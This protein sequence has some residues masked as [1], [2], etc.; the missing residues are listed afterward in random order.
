M[1]YQLDEMDCGPSCLVMIAKYYGKEF[2]LSFFRESSFITKNGVSLLGISQAAQTIGFET[3]SAKLTLDKLKEKEVELP[4]ILH[5]NQ[6]HFLVLYKIK[7]SRLLKKTYYYLADP[8][9][10]FIKID[11]E[12]FC[13][14]WIASSM[15]GIALYLTPGNSFF[16]Q[17]EI[18][19]QNNFSYLLNYIKPFKWQ[20]TKIFATLFLGSLLTLAFPFLTENLVDKGIKAK[21][22]NLVTLILLAQLFLFFGQTIVEII[23]NR[24]LLYVGSKININIIA[25]FFGKL[26]SMPL[27]YFDAKRIG[28][29]TQRIQDHKRI[30]NFLTSQS[31]QILFSLINFSV[32]FAVLAYYKWSLLLVYTC[33]TL[34]SILWVLY[35]QRQRKILDY[36]RFDLLADNQSTTY[37][38][39]TGMQEIKLNNFEEYKKNQ[40]KELQE[41]LLKIN[42]KV[43]NL[44]QFQLSGY[45]FLNSLKNIVVTFI[46]AQNVIDNNLTLGSMLSVSYI[47]GEMNSPI[48]QLI[49][50]FRSLQD[51]K[52]SFS[53]LNEIHNFKV[54]EN[55]IPYL[56]TKKYMINDKIDGILLNDISF[57]Y[58]GPK[59]EYVL[60]KI[61]HFIPANK[62]TAIVGS[63]GSGKT[64]L[65]KIL[66]KHYDVTEGEIF[67]NGKN[68]KDT[69]LE[70]WRNEY[71][72]V[73]Q[74]GFIFSETIERNIATSDVE[75]DSEKLEN[76]IKI[77]NLSDFINSLPLGLKTKIGSS[78]SGISG[79]Q[80]QRILI[81]RAVYR[82]PKYLFFDEATSSLDAE[83][84]R[85]IMENLN[86]FFEDKTVLI[87]AHR[88]STVKNADQIIVLKNGKIIEIGTHKELVNKKADYFNLVKNQLE[89]GI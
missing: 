78:G 89:L 84:E 68:L 21:N 41:K 77:A 85:I 28:D 12:D 54:N 8:A 62:I 39:V 22:I 2:S 4:C 11:E 43:L 64:T 37:E 63:S 72:V 25:D 44:D 23:R 16:K 80:K 38:L 55:Q 81:A 42:V 59:S 26:M 70:E 18:K 74:D 71:G 7:K 19:E 66:L 29:L 27:K 88:L 82:N 6:A 65:L 67:V 53:R 24:I 73:M 50:F 1:T 20:M 48:N 58:E 61:N 40:W 5:W 31:V 15:K 13:K 36:N 35:F 69:K 3:I 57:Q 30:E 76:A 79:G 34:L 56:S 14:G 86:V 17:K 60:Q 47:I 87:V 51:A 32:F 52:L 9:H 45:D 75:I 10:G 49:T 83:N 33:I 46:V